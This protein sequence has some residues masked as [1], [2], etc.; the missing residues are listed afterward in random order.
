MM[1][2]AVLKQRTNQ[3][4]IP[5]EERADDENILVLLASIEGYLE[6]RNVPRTRAPEDEYSC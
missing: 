1:Q 2:P 6:I 4:P 5:R 3:R